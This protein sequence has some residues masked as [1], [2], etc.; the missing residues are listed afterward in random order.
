MQKTNLEKLSQIVTGGMVDLEI[1]T[2]TSSRR[3]GIKRDRPRN[4]G[5]GAIETRYSVRAMASSDH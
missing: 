2:P 3:R 1:L 5:T 4:A